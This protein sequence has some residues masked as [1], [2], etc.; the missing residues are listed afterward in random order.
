[1][2]SGDE[3]EQRNPYTWLPREIDEVR[4]L[5]DRLFEREL[6]RPFPQRLEGIDKEEYQSL[7]TPTAWG[8][9]R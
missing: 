1:M 9:R 8:T 4:L 2:T 6:D 3:R 5:R 7:G